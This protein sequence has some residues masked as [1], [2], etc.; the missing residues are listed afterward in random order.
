MYADISGRS[1]I[2]AGTLPDVKITFQNQTPMR[3]AEALQALDTVLASQRITTIFQGP[4]YVKVFPESEAS[5]EG[6]PIIDLPPD[7]LPDSSSLL[8]YIVKPKQGLGQR[9]MSAVTP[10]AKFHASII[11]IPGGSAVP[12]KAGLPPQ[13][14]AIHGSD[15]ILVLRDYSSNV[16]RMLKVLSESSMLDK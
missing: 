5:V 7:Q 1:I 8:T 15:D 9:L 2:K 16:R 12:A 14:S 3:P 13:I 4:Q 6:G 10:F 11:Y